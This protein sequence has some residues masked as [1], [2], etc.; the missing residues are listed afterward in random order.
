MAPRPAKR[1]RGSAAA[2]A[3]A[4]VVAEP[5]IPLAAAVPEAA[6]AAAED[7][8]PAL[9][10]GDT[11]EGAQEQRPTRGRTRRRQ[12]TAASKPAEEQRE[13][14]ASPPQTE[15]AAQEGEEEAAG[16]PKRKGGGRRREPDPP[17]L[18]GE[19][20]PTLLHP[21]ARPAA[22]LTPTQGQLSF[23]LVLNTVRSMP[24]CFVVGPPVNVPGASAGLQRSHGATQARPAP[25]ARRA[26]Q[27]G[28]AGTPARRGLRAATAASIKPWVG[29]GRR[30]APG[31][32]TF[33]SHLQ[34]LLPACT[35]RRL[36]LASQPLR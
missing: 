20:T 35:H 33:G 31:G 30:W 14:G 21:P 8:L 22:A 3:A 17:P 23:L 19:P 27:R 16:K 32:W 9:A 29:A 13:Q 5:A 2:A 36:L 6:P 4:G 34:R 15:A 12:R 1:Q 11:E 26:A 25:P 10:V 28:A 24:G 18:A 7:V